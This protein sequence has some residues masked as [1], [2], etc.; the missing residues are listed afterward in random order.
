MN[1]K[2][3]R[4]TFKIVASILLVF[5]LSIG[6]LSS[7]AGAATA[8]EKQYNKQCKTKKQKK[9]KKC[10]NLKKKIDKK[11]STTS[12]PAKKL[13]AKPGAL[14]KIDAKSVGVSTTTA[15]NNALGKLLNGVY[16]IAGVVAVLTLIIA[17]LR[18][19]T[20]G[21]NPETVATARKAIIYACVGLIVIISAFVITQFVI[22]VGST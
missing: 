18:M 9:T 22:S 7:G 4:L 1:S 14:K 3:Q 12:G 17:G 2:K 21:D 6:T 11:T 10:K 15:D 5:T 13:G 19:I 20:G 8:A 16:Q